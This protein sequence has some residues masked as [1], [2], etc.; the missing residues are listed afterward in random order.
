MQSIEN[1]HTKLVTSGPRRVSPFF[2]PQMISDIAAGHVSIKHNLRGPNYATVS[3]C[4]SSAHAVGVSMRTI[5]YGDADIMVCGGSEASVTELGVSGFNNMKA[6]STRNDEPHKASRPFDKD[7]DGF[8]IGEGGGMVV[9]EDLQHALKRGAT[10]YGEMGGIGFTADAFHITQ[11]APEGEG[12]KR[13]MALAVKD[14]GLDFSQIHYINAHGTSTY[15]NDKNETAA[16]KVVFGEHADNLS[17]SS[18]KSMTGHMLGAS[19]GLELIISMLAVRENQIPPTINYDTPDPECDLKY[20]PN[21]SIKKEVFAA[22]SN[23]FGFGGHN[24]SLLV[25]KYVQ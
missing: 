2:I 8:I 23:S 21:K 13:A 6:L 24:V 7:R 3:A 22:L 5:Q 9:L 4:S 18:T 19:G 14:S 12:A 20:T 17:I 25:K 16:I 1:E 10:I 11:P 15:F